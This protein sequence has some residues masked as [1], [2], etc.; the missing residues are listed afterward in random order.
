MMQASLDLK[1]FQLIQLNSCN[2]H[3]FDCFTLNLSEESFQEPASSVFN[4]LVLPLK[5]VAVYSLK[6]MQYF[7]S[8]IFEYRYRHLGHFRCFISSCKI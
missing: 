6:G 3:F 1:K 5:S 7:I 2:R 4:L 8:V